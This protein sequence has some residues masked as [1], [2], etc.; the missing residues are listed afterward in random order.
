MIYPYRYKN[1]MLYLERLYSRRECW[2]LSFREQLLT[3]S[4]NTNNYAEAAMRVLKDK[5]LQRTKAFNPSQLFDL[6][7]ERLDTYYEAR[8]TDVVFGRWGAQRTRFLALE[9]KIQARNIKQ[10]ITTH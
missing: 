1:Y 2:A 10:V 8:I 4:N 9:T 7:T 6:L 5:I 3:R